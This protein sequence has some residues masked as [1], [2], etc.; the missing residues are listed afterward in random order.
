METHFLPPRRIPS[1]TSSYAALART[2]VSNLLVFVHGFRGH[3]LQTWQ[4]FDELLPEEPGCADFDYVFYGYDAFGSD[5]MASAAAFRGFLEILLTEPAS[6]WT[7]MLPIQARRDGRLYD[8]IT[9]V[10]HSL[11]AVVI[12]CALL[13]LAGLG[14]VGLEKLNLIFFAP[15]HS[16]AHLSRVLKESISPISLLNFF[17]AIVRLRSPLIEQ[18]LPDSQELK[19]LN[20]ATRDLLATGKYKYLVAKNVFIAKSENVVINVPFCQ[21]PPAIAIEANHMSVCKSNDAESEPFGHLVKA[22]RTKA[23]GA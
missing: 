12:R 23:A 3:A 14:A 9:L 5:L 4:R 11:G 6:I 8:R 15:A 13:D 22:I 7:G 17:A 21:D 2:Q 18:L 1:H 16:G 10:G 20:Q 19:H